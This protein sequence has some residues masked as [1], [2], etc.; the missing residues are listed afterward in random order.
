MVCEM[1]CA[2]VREG[3]EE[4]GGRRRGMEGGDERREGRVV[5]Q[6]D[7][8]RSLHVSKTRTQRTMGALTVRYVAPSRP[9]FGIG[10]TSSVHLNPSP[11][12]ISSSP[13]GPLLYS[14]TRLL[15]F[16]TN[17]VLRTSLMWLRVRSSASS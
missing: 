6:E 3:R 9:K 10:T 13:F 14:T 8:L 1:G 5:V 11:F 4:G 15:L 7:V 12:L 17:G 16:R 2:E